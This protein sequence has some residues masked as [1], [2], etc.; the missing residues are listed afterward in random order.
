MDLDLPVCKPPSLQQYVVAATAIALLLKLLHV[1]PRRRGALEAAKQ[2]MQELLAT[3]VIALQS[4]P[5]PLLSAGFC[6][7]TPGWL[8]TVDPQPSLLEALMCLIKSS[9]PVVWS[10]LSDQRA[11]LDAR[12]LLAW[13]QRTANATTASLPQFSVGSQQW[14][15][16]CAIRLY[17]CVESPVASVIN[18][19]LTQ[20]NVA[21]N[22]VKCIAPMARRVIG[23][24]HL[25]A[26]GSSLHWGALHR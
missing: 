23:A 7:W 10:H 17:T 18:D 8:D 11:Q 14:Q 19:M 1:D 5:P 15:D 20:S 4:Q 22:D 13:Y 3:L 26:L 25:T 9:L 16:A 2:R 24:V 21:A 12:T 6:P